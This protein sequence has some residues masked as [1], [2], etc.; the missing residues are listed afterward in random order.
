MSAEGRKHLILTGKNGSGKTSTLD[1]LSLYFERLLPMTE[2]AHQYQFEHTFD[3]PDDDLGS[4]VIPRLSSGASFQKTVEAGQFVLAYYYA[5]RVSSV[6]VS[7]NIERVDLDMHNPMKSSAGQKLVKYMVNLK[8]TQAFALQKGDQKRAVEIEAWF[9]RF[10]GIL[11]TVFDD[12]ELKL[13][14]DIDTFAFTILQTGHQPFDFNQMSSGYSAVFAIIN[15]LLIRMEPQRRYDLEGVVLIDEIDAHLH[16]ELQKK[17]LPILTTL[18]PRLQFIVTTHSP[19][20]LS[21]LENSV[22]FDLENPTLIENGAFH[23]D[24]L[25]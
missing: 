7:K 11:R 23:V 19:F 16:L 24:S 13:D 21:S 2:E 9:V 10:E 6:E 8:T 4:G 22:V 14:F 15:D 25:P 17:I 1:A 5:T 18:F 3:T 12:P 20:I